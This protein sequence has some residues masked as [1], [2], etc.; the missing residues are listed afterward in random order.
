MIVLTQFHQVCGVYGNPNIAAFECVDVNNDLESCTYF[1]C[2]FNLVMLISSVLLGG[3]C[4]VHNPFVSKN[5]SAPI[6]RDCTA[7]EGVDTVKCVHG[8]CAVESCES[9]WVVNS[10]RD[11][12]VTQAENPV[13]K[14]QHVPRKRVVSRMFVDHTEPENKDEQERSKVGMHED[15]YESAYYVY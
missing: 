10:N 12:C 11:G 2:V 9:G 15:Y 5:A 13:F 7:I 8:I 4:V 1:E 14:A 3:G 6:G